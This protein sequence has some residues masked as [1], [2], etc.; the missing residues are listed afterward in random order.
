MKPDGGPTM[1]ARID[2]LYLENSL[3]SHVFTPHCDDGPVD[4]LDHP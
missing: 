2:I 4:G 3:A 1:F